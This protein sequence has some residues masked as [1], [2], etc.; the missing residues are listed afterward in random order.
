MSKPLVSIVVP[1]YNRIDLVRQVLDAFA[2]H[3]TA[4]TFEVI[5]V[6]DGSEPPASETLEK[7]DG[8]IR[9]VVQPNRGRASAVN[10]GLAAAAGEI[11]IVCDSDI[12]PSEGFV[13]DH[14][15]FHGSH[16]EIEDTHLGEVRWGVSPSPFA[17]LLG[18]R[19]NPRMIGCE[20]LVHWTRWYTDNWSFKRP[21]INA[22]LVRFDDSFRVWGWE[23]LELAHRLKVRG[24]R[25]RATA[26]AVGRHLQ[27]PSLDGMLEKFAAS[28]PNLL[29]LAACTGGE[30]AVAGWLAHRRTSSGILAASESILREAVRQFELTSDRV[31]RLER[32]LLQRLRVRLSDSVF[33]CGIQRGFLRVDGGSAG[34]DAD[35][36]SP[37]VLPQADVVQTVCFVLQSIGAPAAARQLLEYS[38]G[39]VAECIGD[40]QLATRFLQRAAGGRQ[41]L[42]S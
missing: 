21:L 2:T 27:C 12:V 20:G 26:S 19:A 17:T 30:E 42:N 37:A 29:H 39:T 23:D 4:A 1:V 33:R 35:D 5:V 24:I 25:N 6:D 11:L 3:R 31:F 18:P 41:G 8:R 28:V 32:D 13:D 40:G 16:P 14:L 7:Q 38:A 9:L 36:P 10:A 15:A 22:G 34:H